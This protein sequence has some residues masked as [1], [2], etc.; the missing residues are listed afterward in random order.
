MCERCRKR[1]RVYLGGAWSLSAE[2]AAVCGPV[3]HE[4]SRLRDPLV[5]RPDVEAVADACH[6]LMH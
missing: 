3:A 6:E 5:L 2:V 4:A 1:Q